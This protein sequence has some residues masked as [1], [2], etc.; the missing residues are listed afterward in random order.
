MMITLDH[1]AHRYQ[2]LPSEA[3]SRAT[4]LDLKVLH[5]SNAWQHHQHQQSQQSADV[6][7]PKVVKKLT[8]QQLQAMIDS[9]RKPK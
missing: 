1:L 6:N 2:C 7:A 5:V 3:L 9:V 4:T 8:Q